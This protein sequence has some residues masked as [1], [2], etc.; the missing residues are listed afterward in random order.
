M[1]VEAAGKVGEA[2]V[3]GRDEGV[4]KDHVTASGKGTAIVA[5]RRT[6]NRRP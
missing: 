1:F 3:V 6:D 5:R 2:A 4:A